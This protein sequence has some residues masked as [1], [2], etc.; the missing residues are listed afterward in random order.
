[1]KKTVLVLGCLLAIGFSSV[2]CNRDDSLPETTVNI[3]SILPKPA[4]HLIA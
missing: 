1:M 4:D 3:R 2:S